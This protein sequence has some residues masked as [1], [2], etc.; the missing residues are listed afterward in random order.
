MR[1]KFFFFILAACIGATAAWAQCPQ[2]FYDTIPA[3][4]YITNFEI[5]WENNEGDDYELPYLKF[6]DTFRPDLQLDRMYSIMIEARH[7][8]DLNTGCKFRYITQEDE[9]SATLHWY[10]YEYWPSLNDIQLGIGAHIENRVS[11]LGG[12]CIHEKLNTFF[13][14]A[15]E[16]GVKEVILFVEP[17]Y[18]D[19][20]AVTGE[21]KYV[22]FYGDADS[23]DV[24]N[25]NYFTYTLPDIVKNTL[26]AP[27]EVH[28]DNALRIESSIQAFGSV[29]YKLQ[30][31][32]AGNW[33]TIQSGSISTA[34]ARLGK[35]IQYE[36]EFGKGHASVCEYRMIVTD[37]TSGKADTSNIQQVQFLY[38]AKFNN[39][40]IYRS[41]GETF[42]SYKA[43]DCHEYKITSELPVAQKVEGDMI[44]WTMPACDLEIT[45]LQPIT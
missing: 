19:V 10:R 37:V 43:E 8:N 7:A 9:P 38:K 26:A 5:V 11:S 32:S 18:K 3:Q 30:E 33:R 2:Y 21:T 13:Q 6:E 25:I 22:S 41:P 15:A 16:K 14:Y 4:R 35:T 1:K 42:Y 24:H 36:E 29:T 27:K 31:R 17:Q 44:K 45:Y 40:V 39:N 34:E 23:H 28:S 20:N 12:N